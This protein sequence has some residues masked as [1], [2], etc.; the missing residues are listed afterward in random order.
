MILFRATLA[1][2]AR[3]FTTPRDLPTASNAFD[4]N[5]NSKGCART[6]TY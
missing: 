4:F 1:I 2:A 5:A 3:V 6:K